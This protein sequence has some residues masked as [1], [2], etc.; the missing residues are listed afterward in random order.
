MIE[1]LRK[2]YE[3]IANIYT[4]FIL[5][6]I[7]FSLWIYISFSAARRSGWNKLKAKFRYKKEIKDVQYAMG[8]GY[9]SKSFYRGLRIGLCSDGIIIGQYMHLFLFHPALF[10][11][12]SQLSSIMISEPERSMYNILEQNLGAKISRDTFYAQTAEIS[13]R[14]YHDMKIIFPWQKTYRV[15]LP[16]DLTIIGNV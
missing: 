11:P 15:F 16:K 7:V 6:V 13:F 8:T 14:D 12:W 2:I 5:P 1:L 9:F 10:F 3:T 4:P